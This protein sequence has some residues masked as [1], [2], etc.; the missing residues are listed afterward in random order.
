MAE[1]FL[2][3]KLHSGDSFQLKK[4]YASQLKIAENQWNQVEKP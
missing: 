4:N 1:V 3:K 2:Q